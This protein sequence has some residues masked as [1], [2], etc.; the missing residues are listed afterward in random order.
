MKLAD[1]GLR[2]HRDM[3][4]LPLLAAVAALALS[5][6]QGTSSAAGASSSPSAELPSASPCVGLTTPP[7][8][9]PSSS[10]PAFTDPQYGFTVSHPRG[11]LFYRATNLASLDP[12]LVRYD[13]AD[14]CPSD[15][16]GP[17]WGVG[18]FIYTRDAGTLTAWLQK[19]TD[20]HSCGIANVTGFLFNVTNVKSV[21]VT[22]RDAVSFDENLG[23]CGEGGTGAAHLTAFFLASSHVLVLRWYSQDSNYAPTV[24]VIAQE[25]LGSVRG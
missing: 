5:C 3:R 15:N 25:M 13:V 24:Q 2:L 11:L 16:P 14:R 23:A 20:N 22:G 7:P 12:V 8:L 18:T 21:T 4:A 6:S 10:W 19:H 1:R 9:S 17:S